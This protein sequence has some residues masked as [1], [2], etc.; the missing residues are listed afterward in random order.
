MTTHAD[1]TPKN[2]NQ[3]V[4][5]SL[6][7]QQ[8]NSESTF[9]FV[10]NRPEAIAHT[11]L[12]EAINTSPRVR[13][14]NAYQEMANNS[15]QVKQLTAYQAMADKF[16]SPVVQRKENS[17]K[18]ILQGKFEPTIQRYLIVANHDITREYKEQK[19]KL[20]T[21]IDQIFLYMIFALD[22]RNP[23]EG[24]MIQDINEDKNTGGLLRKQLT[25]WIEDEPGKER[26]GE[27]G[28]PHSLF[29]RKNQTRAYEN[30]KDLAYALLGWVVAKPG[31]KEEKRLAKSVQGGDHRD[32]I[33]Y[34]LNSILLKINTWIDGRGIKM[35]GIK[36][37]LALPGFG[38]LGEWNIYQ[39]YFQSGALDARTVLP[40]SFIH[41]LSN[42]QEYD[43]REKT[44]MLH[45]IMHYFMEKYNKDKSID[46]VDKI[47][48]LN[49]TA[50][51]PNPNSIDGTKRV[52]YDRPDNTKIR[53]E[54]KDDKGLVKPEA[55]PLYNLSKD[56]TKIEISKEEQHETY[57]LARSKGLPMYGRH[58]GSAARLMRMVQQS[59]GTPTERSAMA[60]SIM[61]YWR[62]NYDHTNIPYHTLHEVM[63]F[64]PEFGGAY[65]VDAPY[66]GINLFTKEGLIESLRASILA[67]PEERDIDKL[68]NTDTA[69]NNAAWAQENRISLK[70]K[71]MSD[72]DFKR[73][74]PSDV[75]LP[76]DESENVVEFQNDAME[77]N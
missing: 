46:L 70:E 58:S 8:R 39:K 19:I 69:P 62:L 16:A 18:E 37:E 25:K 23:E 77:I 12:Q 65:D 59:G 55:M 53:K 73:L 64:L 56:D 9:Q 47:E 51:V 33:D 45:D 48:N 60:W 41:V 66:A 14:L 63:D 49:L 6:Q 36:N 35:Q 76:M 44:G 13:Q 2:K 3:A 22:K 43:V 28:E 40:A 71:G 38:D 1:K 10:D 30:F 61:S 11:E 24:K 75:P 29:G 34:H 57:K 54:H 50:T 42:P 20:E 15:P 68:I 7:K 21:R 74:M 31:R 4:S 72:Q 5:N 27:I 67:K 17:K 52:L 32:A 26:T